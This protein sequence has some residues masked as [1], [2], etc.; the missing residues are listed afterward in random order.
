MRELSDRLLPTHAS[1]LSVS[2]AQTDYAGAKHAGS[3][4]NTNTRFSELL[5]WNALAAW[6]GDPKAVTRYQVGRVY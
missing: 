4:G 3:Q 5:K 6:R 1:L 2:D